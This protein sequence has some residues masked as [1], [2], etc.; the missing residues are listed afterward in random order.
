MNAHRN[1]QYIHTWSQNGQNELN[2]EKQKERT[3]PWV[4]NLDNLK[5]IADEIT[6]VGA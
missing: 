6:N 3:A 4:G 1:K 5:D 2:L